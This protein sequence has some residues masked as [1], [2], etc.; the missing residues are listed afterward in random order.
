M[1]HAETG[2]LIAEAFAPRHDTAHKIE[3]DLKAHANPGAKARIEIVDGDNGSAFAW[4]AAGRFDPPVVKL[5]RINPS[6]VTQRQKLAA[7]LIGAMPLHDLAPELG[8]LLTSG[9]TAPEVRAEAAK[10]MMKLK[11]SAGLKALVPLTGDA[12]IPDALQS[13]IAQVI[14]NRDPRQALRAMAEALTIAPRQHSDPNRRRARRHRDR[15]R[16]PA[17][18]DLGQDGDPQNSA[19]LDGRR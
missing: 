4:I 9:T 14:V 15:I 7:G 3:W 6:K 12:S 10:S 17:P 16:T 19:Q 2:A 8:R 1:R 5:P 13:R 11:P 18:V